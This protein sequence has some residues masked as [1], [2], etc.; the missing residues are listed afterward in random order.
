MPSSSM[1]EGLSKVDAPLVFLSHASADTEPAR[2]L[3][4]GLRGAGLRVWLD[5]DELAPGDLWMERIESALLGAQAFAVY[6]GPSGVQR[7]VDRE[8]R[9]AL[10]RSVSE[11]GFSLIPVLGPGGSLEAL[12][13]FLRQHQ[14]LDLR[15]GLDSGGGLAVLVGALLEQGPRRVRLLPAD[16]TPF[17]G[18]L[19]FDVANSHLFFGRDQEAAELLEGLKRASFVA[20]VGGSGTGKSSLVR[21]GLVPLLHRGRFLPGDPRGGNWRVAICRPRRASLRRAGPMPA[22]AR[23]RPLG[24][25]ED[26]GGGRGALTARA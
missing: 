8:T 1:A 21:A 2:Q 16:E 6:V 11:P 20:V 3:A 5:A 9:L 24:F 15:E 22:G 17:R 18:L 13:F 14:V 25:R 19:A 7:W 23:P 4:R 10:E 26:S 12:P